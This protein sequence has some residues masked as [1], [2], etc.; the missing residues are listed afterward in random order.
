MQIDFIIVWNN[1]RGM[2]SPDLVW[3]H[4]NPAGVCGEPAGHAGG[5]VECSADLRGEKQGQ[6]AQVGR[7]A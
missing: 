7:P 2:C 6:A 1:A 4:N 5:R 3:M